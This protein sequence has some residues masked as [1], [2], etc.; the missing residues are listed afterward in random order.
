MLHMKECHPRTAPPITIAS[1]EEDGRRPVRLAARRQREMMVILRD[2]LNGESAEWVDSEDIDRP[3]DL[4]EHDIVSSA[5]GTSLSVIDQDN[6][7]QWASI[8]WE[9]A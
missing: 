3:T 1:L 4:L 7:Q 9:D 5:Q 8:P 6:M 2:H